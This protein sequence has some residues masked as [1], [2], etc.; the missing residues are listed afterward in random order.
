MNSAVALRQLI[1]GAWQPGGGARFES[2]SP[3]SPHVVVA[4]GAMADVADV[5]DAIGAA[6][7]ALSGWA[8][9][10]IHQR[11][12]VLAAAAVIV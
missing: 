8:A 12:A 2:S 4:E 9:V 1:A 7:W 5:D 3:T 10:P 6:R 11:G